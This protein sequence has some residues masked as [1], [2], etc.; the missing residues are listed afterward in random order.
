M[1]ILMTKEVYSVKMNK[2]RVKISKGGRVVI[3]AEYRKA[4][5]LQTGDE[6]VIRIDEGELHLFTLNH[7]IRHAQ[8]IV[9]RYVPKK[10]SLVDELI[11]E[12]HK[13]AEN[14]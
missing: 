5:G 1:S 12:R 4:L 13:E 10:R 9:R 14:E 6:V 7:A 3:P 11:A 2:T 8:E